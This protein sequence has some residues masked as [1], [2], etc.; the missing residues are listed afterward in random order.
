MKSGCGRYTIVGLVGALYAFHRLFCKRYSCPRCGPRKVRYV[1]K[2]IAQRAL[3]YG[4]RRFLTLTLDPKKLKPGCTLREK[5]EY[6]N[7]VWRKMRVYLQRRLGKSLVFIAVVELQSN[8][9]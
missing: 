6:L 4:L 3:Q 1:R 7:A 5:V 8:G 9:T 2:R